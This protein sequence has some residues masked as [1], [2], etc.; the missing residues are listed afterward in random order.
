MCRACKGQTAGQPVAS[1][2]EE[3]RYLSNR[4]KM[5]REDFSQKSETK[6]LDEKYVV[7]QLELKLGLAKSQQ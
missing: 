2:Q 3:H 6:S 5:S 7:S 4:C 1:R